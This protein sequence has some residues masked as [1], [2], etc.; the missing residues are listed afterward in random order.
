MKQIIILDLARVI[1]SY[2][3][4]SVHFIIMKQ[5][6][7]TCKLRAFL[8]FYLVVMSIV[9]VC[10]LQSCGRNNPTEAFY[11]GSTIQEKITLRSVGSKIV[12]KISDSV[13][14]EVREKTLSTFG[15]IENQYQNV[16]FINA[17]SPEKAKNAVDQLLKESWTVSVNT[18]YS[19]LDSQEMGITNE[20]VFGIKKKAETTA[21]A[22]LLSRF[23]L[24]EVPY[25]RKGERYYIL[26]TVGKGQSALSVANKLMESGEVEFAHPN[27]YAMVYKHSFIPNDE[28]FGK[29]F[30]LN[31]TG[32]LINDGHSGTPDAD[33]DAPDA[34]DISKGSA[35]ITIAVIDEGT[36]RL[37]T[38]L[39]ASRLSIVN[40]S[41][42][43]PMQNANDPSP[44]GDG[45]HGTCCSG[46]I[47]AEQNNVEGVSGVAPLCHVMPVKIP[48]GVVP[49]TTYANAINFAWSNGADI[50]SNSWG[51]GSAANIPVITAAITNAT[52]MGRGGVGSVVVFSAGNTANQVG[53]NIGF[54]A[55]PGSAPVA[56][57]ITV[58]A[59]NRDDRQSNY[60]PTSAGVTV[61]APSHHAYS[62]QIA[63]E[64]F[65]VWSTDIVGTAGYN[66]THST[67]GGALP[68][69][70]THLPSSGTN[71]D[72]YT[73]RMGGTS[74]ACPEVSGVCGLILATHS[75]L[76]PAQVKQRIINCCDK[77]GGYTYV[78]GRCNDVG[79]GR[80]NAFN[81]LSAHLWMQDTPNDPG[82]DPNSISTIFYTSDDIWV[83]P[84]NDGGTTHSDPE[85]R[86]PSAPGAV[87]NAV[88]VKIR[89]AGCESGSA[90]VKL[91]WAKAST[92]LS[93]PAPWDGSV[94]SPA[95]M[96]GSIGSL[97]VTVAANGETVL[98]FNWFPPNPTDYA[99]FGADQAHFCL[100]ARIERSPVAPFGMAFP[101]TADLGGNVKNN[102]NIV[103][104]NVH[105]IPDLAGG[106]THAT[107][108]I[109][110]Y[111]KRSQLTKLQFD[112]PQLKINDFLL[113]NGE[114][115]ISL[116]DVMMKKWMSG[117]MK[118]DGFKQERNDLIL[119]SGKAWIGNFV[120]N[121]REILPLKTQVKLK[122]N[123]EKNTT[124]YYTFRI[125]QW[126]VIKDTEREI[127]GVQYNLY[128]YKQPRK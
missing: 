96:G 102:D 80:V 119:T 32:Q 72:N 1:S 87:A 38:D 105:V 106:H 94:V 21:K 113:R 29:Q 39:P 107:T 5:R 44:S 108:L 114:I 14:N 84:T 97:P 64:S 20:I 7:F 118:G 8:P 125:N 62:S 37:N 36:E 56:D 121:P 60:S 30:Y 23:E 115:R 83:R 73:G 58:G 75:T 69:V 77:I 95:L 117:G 48:F 116:N 85:Y 54:V 122:T 70:G 26:A 13:R 111:T 6:T 103:W 45:A 46:I 2:P 51:Y 88:Y 71:F 33:I 11:Y 27:F 49:S 24:K 55:F 93:Y 57:L 68:V 81:A 74:A 63:G 66:Q 18:L 34:W 98:T 3:Y 15:I 50:L 110:N 120:L 19:T 47:A 9:T 35:S 86:D 25:E 104:K 100:L 4:H 52:T 22:S 127:G 92:G 109:A 59:S 61:V 123:P 40:G 16:Y 12:V 41:N 65:E 126:E 79:F 53:G 17:K 67:D 112:I 10:I 91:Y 76:T 28:Y 99:S 82:T 90:T 31:N 42:F 128:P 124:D 101:E 89:N 43:V 78:G